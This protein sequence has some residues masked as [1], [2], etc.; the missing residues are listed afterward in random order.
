VSAARPGR[1]PWRRPWLAVVGVTAVLAATSCGNEPAT[2][3]QPPHPGVPAQPSDVQGIYR[4]IRQGL[5]QLRGNGGF[6][7]IAAQG[8]GPSAGEYTLSNGLLNVV[9]NLCGQAIGEYQVTVGGIPE[10]G[11]ATLHFTVV[12]DDCAERAH[13]LTV[14]A[15]VYADS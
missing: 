1:P 4:N 7:L 3:V 12:R 8:S 10:P 15:W 5:L 13:D 6:V 2:N 9:T 11:D 14:E